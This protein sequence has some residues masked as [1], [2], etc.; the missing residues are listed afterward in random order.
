VTEQGQSQLGLRLREVRERRGLSISQAAADTRILP[1]Y[2]QALEEGKY[3][4]LPGDV[5]AR[6]FIRNY[7]QYLGLPAEDLIQVYRKER[8]NPT[9]GKIPIVQPG[10]NI[11]RRS[12][13][14][15]STF[16][17]FLIVAALCVVSYLVGNAFDFFTQPLMTTTPGRSITPQATQRPIPSA[18]VN[19]TAVSETATVLSGGPTG[20]PDT[21]GQAGPTPT[22]EAPLVVEVRVVESASWIRV[23]VDGIVRMEE[24]RNPGWSQRFTA[25]REIIV[26]AGNSR[27]VEVVVNNDPPQ[28]MGTVLGQPQQKMFTAP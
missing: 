6:G 9:T 3:D 26:R 24:T 7:A 8:G 10:N 5:Y 2:L 25:Q 22:L 28:R 11:R 16:M 12:C 20:T 15:P 19:P 17:V 18:T 1:R 23:I 13:I 27:D 21:T 4:Q 14:A